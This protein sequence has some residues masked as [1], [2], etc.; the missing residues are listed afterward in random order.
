[1]LKEDKVGMALYYSAVKVM[2]WFWFSDGS[3][4]IQIWAGPLW[5][6]ALE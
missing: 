5:A 4:N 2:G 3:L 1:M 6:Q